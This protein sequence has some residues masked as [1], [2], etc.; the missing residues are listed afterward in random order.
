MK[1]KPPDA[2]I[3]PQTHALTLTQPS[4]HAGARAGTAKPGAKGA[5]KAERSDAAEGG[6]RGGGGRV[7]ETKPPDANRVSQTLTPTL[8]PTLAL[9]LALS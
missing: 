6:L 9:T 5:A 2:N 8:T 4:R 3:A 7:D 1:T